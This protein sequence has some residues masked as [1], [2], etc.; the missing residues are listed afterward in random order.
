VPTFPSSSGEPASRGAPPDLPRLAADLLLVHPPAIYPFRERR[1]LYFPFLG[2]SGDVPITPLYEYFPVGYKSL[3]RYLGER[4][5]RVRL[6]NLASLLLRYP[7][8]GLGD[9]ID[10][11]DA[12]VVGIDLH[13]MV[14]VQG[15]LAVAERLAA[16]RPD[17]P[18][19]L[20]GL[21]AT[22]YA[23]ELIRL[24][25]VDLVMRGYDTHAPVDRLLGALG[26]EEHLAAVPNLLWK[27]SD[28]RIVDNGL[29]FLPEPYGCAVDW[30]RLPAAPAQ[31]AGLPIQEILTVHN[32]G[33]RHDCAWCGS[34]RSA[35]R[36]IHQ[37]AHGFAAKPNAAVAGELRTV[38]RMAAV[39]RHHLYAVGA[40][41]QSPSELS[42]ALDRLDG[43]A[44]RS[45]SLEQIQLTPDSLLARMGKLGPRVTITLSPQSH[46]PEVARR[47]GR[48]VFTNAEMEAW[49]ERALDHGIAGIDL[50]YFVGMPGQTEQ[51]VLDNV[52]YCVSLLE[53]YRGKNV[54]P[55]ICPMVPLLDPGSTIFEAPAEHGYRLFCRS[56][57][58]HRRAMQRPSFLQRINYETRWLT[59]WELVRVGFRAVRDLMSAKAEV[60]M[61]RRSTIERYNQRIDDALA[62]L[63]VVDEIDR[64]QDRSERARQL[65]RIG[66]EIVERNRLVLSPFVDNQAFPV[67]RQIGGRW[68]DELGW[69]PEL[70]APYE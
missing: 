27:A 59:R 35:F 61:H 51:L 13:W 20:G 32:A 64:L 67:R 40:Y 57:D 16:A 6:L 69:A 65:D 8:L 58:D 56:V 37:C 19:L 25:F 54:Q 11:L 36:R 48:G 47:A 41:N 12:A 22:Y 60:G 18:I 68:F 38:N 66:D 34:S 46:D 43:L 9:V 39:E 45:L 26:S 55:L 29:T 1:D 70:L 30:A 24:P 23:E 5:H 28:G 4:G 14:H 33:C 49:I 44:C 10:R 50:W 15:A 3:E 62:F 53:R 63:P 42:L 31:R 17:L 21:S 2:T 52:D 7:R